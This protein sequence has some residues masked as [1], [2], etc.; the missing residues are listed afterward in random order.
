MVLTPDVVSI[1]TGWAESKRRLRVVA[2]L[3]GVNVAVFCRVF[4]VTDDSF[5]LRIGLDGQDGLA[6][7]L[8]GWSFNFGTPLTG[9]DDVIEGEAIESAIVGTTQTGSVLRLRCYLAHLNR[10]RKGT[11]C[12]QTCAIT[13]QE[14]S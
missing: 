8:E 5:S 6:F 1:L 7:K 13:T 14:N 12:R 10:I 11:P 9:V 3:G 4:G 2:K